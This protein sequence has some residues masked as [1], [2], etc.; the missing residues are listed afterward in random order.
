MK[1]LVAKIVFFLMALS[2][3]AQQFTLQGTAAVVNSNTFRLTQDT[4]SQAGLITSLYP[5]NLTQNF[6]LNFELFLGSNYGG[7]ADGIAIMFSK[8]CN[9]TLTA[10]Q[11]LAVGGTPNSL[12]TEFDT[13]DNGTGVF[14]VPQHHITIFKNGLMDQADQVMDV[15][16]QPVCASSTCGI[17]DDNNWHAVKIKWEYLSA[18]L[19]KLSVYFDSNLRVTSTRNHILNSFSNDPIVFYSFGGSTGAVT[20]FQQIRTNDDSVIQNVCSGG[21]VTIVAPELG[22]NYAWSI[23]GSTTNINN[24]TPTSSETVTCNYTDYCGIN[25][26]ISFTINLFPAISLPNLSAVSPLCTGQNGVFTINGT[27]GLVVEYT[28]NNGT[29]QTLTIPASGTIAITVNNPSG[30]QIVKITKVKNA[31]C[32]VDNLNINQTIQVSQIPTTSA[33]IQTN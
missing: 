15:V 2:V 18:T 33:P 14:D 19:Q 30:N 6:E 7:G 10:G 4:F 29:L 5:L 28:I 31:N 8:N 24:F 20:N 17:I 3:N 32:E 26:T 27:P 1:K 25:R 13:Y 23:G 16:T 22:T 11:G 12:I 9:P 21:Q